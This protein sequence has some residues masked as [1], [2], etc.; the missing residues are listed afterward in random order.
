MNRK[1]FGA[2]VALIP[3]ALFCSPFASKL[4]AEVNPVRREA[5]NEVNISAE[6]PRT[7]LESLQ[8]E[9][10]LFKAGVYFEEARWRFSHQDFY[11]AWENIVKSLTLAPDDTAAL[12]LFTQALAL[13]DD[14]RVLAKIE[15]ERKTHQEF[16]SLTVRRALN[17]AR[18]LIRQGR[19]PQAAYLLERTI[20][21][22]SYHPER[23]SC[24]SLV[25]E[26]EEEFTLAHLKKGRVQEI[27]HRRIA[28]LVN[29]ARDYLER[30]EVLKARVLTGLA[31]TLEPRDSAAL[32]LHRA[33]TSPYRAAAGKP[34]AR[35]AVVSKEISPEKG[36]LRESAGDW[37]RRKE[38]R[39]ELTGLAG[40]LDWQTLIYERLQE[41]ISI[42]FTDTPVIDI[43]DFIRDAAD[44]NIVV[45]EPAYGDRVLTPIS[46]KLN[47]VKIE[48]C[49]RWVLSLADLGYTYRDEAIFI[50]DR[51]FIKEAEN[52]YLAI[53]DISDLTAVVRDFVGPSLGFGGGGR[54]G[55]DSDAGG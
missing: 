49:L 37:W 4:L 31:L 42:D 41:V 47:E 22:I 38:P 26:A 16:L 35:A 52:N 13:M 5:S 23:A 53:Y 30:G 12:E 25:E 10:D 21:T 34:R 44:V 6:V 18:L 24:A 8:K 43:I 17:E 28:G 54:G 3:F 46:I 20:D 1:K 45:D 48:S 27:L 9:R 51:E 2:Y 33:I 32:S 14:P 7:T 50:S 15:A 40:Y 19:L 29:Q 55:G 39:G 11:G 36:A